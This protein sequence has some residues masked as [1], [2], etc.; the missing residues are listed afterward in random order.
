MS[1]DPALRQ[2][3]L[4]DFPADFLSEEP[5]ELTEYGRDWTRV[6]APAPSAIAFP[7]NVDE[8]SRLLVLCNESRVSVVPSGGRT[9]LAAGAV[10]A[11][12]EVVLSLSRMRKMDEVDRLG[13][14]VRVE[15]GA[16]TEAV[17]EHCAP[18]GLTWPVDFASKGSS[19]V[20]GNIATN[21]GGVKVI[22]YGLTRQW[23]L[24]LEVVLASG[25]RLEIGGA[26]EKNNTGL[27]L[28]QLFIGS[29][30]TLGIVTAA[31]LKLTRLPGATQVM[32]FG[33]PDVASVL[34]LFREARTGPFTLAAY[35]FFS[36]KCLD[37][38]LS[39][40][41]LRAPLGQACEYYVL[42][43]VEG[44]G[45]AESD[46]ARL[47]ERIEPWVSHV[48][49]S[50]F[51][52]DGTLAQHGS[53]ARELWALREGISESLSATGLPH[54]NDVALPIAGLDPFCAELDDVF[55]Q[56]YPGWEICLFGHVGD[57]NLHINVMKPETMDRAAFFTSTK[58]ADRDLFALVQRH[59]GSISAEHGIG[60]LKKPFLSYSRSPAEIAVMRSVKHALDPNGILN[61]GKILD[62]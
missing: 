22:R 29:E 47:F 43:E 14:T 7:R 41:K 5:S 2:R 39:H 18:H 31:T 48:F 51:A 9:G 55:E 1:L 23:V 8:V 38:V 19:T 27:D 35:E 16:I 40:R 52:V 44:E 37:R 25:E 42:V 58:E 60:L 17:H 33:V 13:A 30:G 21:A 54:K 28:R 26:L 6:L 10:A 3:I 49:E 45:H 50:G 20:G 62:L 4:S 53:Q 46:G 57:G 34:R 15:A 56:R 11:N 24:G 32:L 12:G 36:Q 61:P 59:Q